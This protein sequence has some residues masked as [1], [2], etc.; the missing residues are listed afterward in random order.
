MNEPI[1]NMLDETGYIGSVL[2]YPETYKLYP[3]DPLDFY[4]KKQRDMCQAIKNLS[5]NDEP[6]DFITILGELKKI[7]SDVT[8]VEVTDIETQ[9]PSSMNAGKYAHDIKDLAGKRKLFHLAE[10]VATMCHNG[11]SSID[12]ITSV[13]IE[14]SKIE[15]SGKADDHVYTAKEAASLA[16]DATLD[17]AAGQRAFKFGIKALDDLLYILKKDLVIVGGRPGTGKTV[18]L[19]TALANN[20][21]KRGL[22]LELE[23]GVEQATQRILSQLSGIPAYRIVRGIMKDDESLP[24]TQ[25]VGTFSEWNTVICDLPSMKLSQ[26]KAIARKE[27]AKQPLDYILVDYLQLAS[28]DGK[29]E[30]RAIEVGSVAKGLKDLAKELEIPVIVAAQINRLS[31]ITSEKRPQLHNLKESGDIEQAADSVVF[32]HIADNNRIL[33]VAKQRMG[34]LGDV[35]VYFNEELI[36][37]EDANVTSFN[38]NGDGFK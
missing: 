10:N 26:M 21:D 31:E 6:I 3:L 15:T 29:S 20:P 12:I 13:T 35:P 9:T 14:M 24:F 25:A 17:S 2:L 19:I 7:G 33:I 8:S 5:D 37:F 22:F 11:K 28:G 23:T 18:S 27:H 34:S 1:A 16:Y 4:F 30:T 36:R 38:P 32:V